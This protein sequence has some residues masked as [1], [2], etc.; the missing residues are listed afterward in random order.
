MF[1]EGG[2]RTHICIS[3]INVGYWGKKSKGNIASSKNTLT[4]SLKHLIQNCYFMIGNLPI[5]QKLGIPMEIDPASFWTNFFS[6]TYENKY[7]SYSNDRVKARHFY[8]T[9]C[10]ID[11]LGTLNDGGVF[12]IYRDIYPPELQLK[13]EHSGTHTTFLNLDVTAK[14]GVFIYKIFIKHDAFPFFIIRMPY[15]DSNIPKSI[16]YSALVGEFLRIARLLYKNFHEKAMELLNRM[17]AQG[18]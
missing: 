12:N 4:T 9:K 18:A 14:D 8:A 17:K 11:D 7:I 2:N 15:I 16:F 6:Y 5:R 3:K 13:V 10:F 1:F